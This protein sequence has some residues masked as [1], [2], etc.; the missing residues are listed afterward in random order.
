MGIIRIW[1]EVGWNIRN[2]KRECLKDKI[3]ELVKPSKN[4]SIRE[5]YRGVYE[6]NK[7]ISLEVSW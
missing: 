5:L 6:L 7:I 2:K 1:H 3:N 4:K